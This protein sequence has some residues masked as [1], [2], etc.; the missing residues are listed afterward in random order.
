MRL[1]S[2]LVWM[3]AS[4][5]GIWMIISTNITWISLWGPWGG[6]FC[7]IL[8][9]IAFIGSPIIKLT[10]GSTPLVLLEYLAMVVFLGCVRTASTL[11]VRI[12]Q[13][14]YAGYQAL[15]KELDDIKKG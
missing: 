12:A 9:P 13:G 5:L 15:G 14:K 6:I 8:Y 1:L 7:F 10:Q 3:I 2:I 4:V 11:S